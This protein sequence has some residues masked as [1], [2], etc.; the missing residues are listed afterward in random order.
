LNGL[1]S[2]FLNLKEKFLSFG[3]VV[4]TINGHSHKEIKKHYIKSVNHKI[5]NKL[6]NIVIDAKALALN[7]IPDEKQDMIDDYDKE[8]KN[9]KYNLN[10]RQFFYK[11]EI[12]ELIKTTT[13]FM[14][15]T[16]NKIIF[17]YPH[18][19]SEYDIYRDYFSIKEATQASLK[20][21]KIICILCKIGKAV[22][23]IV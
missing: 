9:F 22:N 4:K 15:S 1:I 11:K 19:S 7:L 20:I 18:K 12:F 6:K 8:Y 17:S 3:W 14:I 2:S 13:P 5:Q 23:C 10:P 21:M 16:N